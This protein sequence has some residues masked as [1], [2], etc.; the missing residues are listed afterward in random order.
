VTVSCMPSRPV[1][2]R[3]YGAGSSA[4]RFLGKDPGTLTT[5]TNSSKDGSHRIYVWPPTGESFPSVTTILGAISKPALVDWSARQAATYAVKERQRLMFMDKQE[6]I[7]EIATTHKRV[8]ELS[9]AVGTHVHECIESLIESGEVHNP[10]PEHMRH[11][12]AWRT[13]YKP[14]FLMSEATVY[15]RAVCYAGTFDILAKI[16]GVT[17][18]IDVKTGKNI[19]PEVALQL[20]AY[21]N[22]EFYGSHDKVN[23]KWCE[24]QLPKIESAA[25]LHLRMTGWRFMTVDIGPEVFQAF[26]HVNETWRWQAYGSHNV[27][28]EKGLLQ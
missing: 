22:G 13:V 28:G 8:T 11:F 24:M 5:P 2:G 1:L 10:W 4:P 9:S 25:V 16:G 3:A 19:Y 20:A 27:L 26:R 14:E 12:E 17:T 23:D 21:A 6:A 7:D 18:L 15:N